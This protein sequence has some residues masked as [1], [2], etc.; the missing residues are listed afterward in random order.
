MFKVNVNVCWQKDRGERDLE[1]VRERQVKVK[2]VWQKR[3]FG[4]ECKSQCE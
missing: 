1:K 3:E 2:E 4:N